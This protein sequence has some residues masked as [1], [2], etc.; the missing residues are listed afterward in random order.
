MRDHRSELEMLLISC[1]EVFDGGHGFPD[2]P[3]SGARAVDATCDR[4]LSGKIVTV[5]LDFD[6]ES[7]AISACADTFENAQSAE[8]AAR[9]FA[10]CHLGD[11]VRQGDL[12]KA[13]QF[14]HT[15]ARSL[16]LGDFALAALG[17]PRSG[18]RR[19]YS[20]RWC[21]GCTAIPRSAFR[22]AIRPVR[23][24]CLFDRT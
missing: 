3:N 19:D 20:C 13:A 22:S 5:A 1:M 24:I 16:S 17:R 15:V 21:K 10:Y 18:C 7:G 8:D 4:A 6:H 23:P 14:N 12:A 2:C 11:A 9:R